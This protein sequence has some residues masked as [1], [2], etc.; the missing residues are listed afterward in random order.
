MMKS[1]IL[2]RS[3]AIQFSGRPREKLAIESLPYSSSSIQLPIF[4]AYE[5]LWLLAKKLK[6]CNRCRCS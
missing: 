3:R 2:G 5:H 6:T 1:R 4:H